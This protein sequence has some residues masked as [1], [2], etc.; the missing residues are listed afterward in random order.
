V[1]TS[2]R[3]VYAYASVCFILPRSLILSLSLSRSLIRVVSLSVFSSL[4]R[5]NRTHETARS[6]KLTH[7]RI[8]AAPVRAHCSI[9]SRLFTGRRH[10][11][12]HLY[13]RCFSYFARALISLRLIACGR[14]VLSTSARSRRGSGEKKK[15]ARALRFVHTRAHRRALEKRARRCSA[16]FLSLSLS[17]THTHTHTH[18]QTRIH[19]LSLSLSLSKSDFSNASRISDVRGASR[20]RES[21][22]YVYAASSPRRRRPPSL[23]PSL[24]PPITCTISPSRLARAARPIP[25][26]GVFRRPERKLHSNVTLV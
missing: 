16:L 26:R 1:R 13:V 15:K 6:S 21:I 20:P 23:P 9:H 8:R 3:P 2:A 17:H 24:R 7:I 18:V 14:P 5:K 25:M 11:C 19:S 4:S 10:L 12:P 22:V